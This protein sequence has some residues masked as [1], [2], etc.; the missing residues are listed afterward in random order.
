MT[1]PITIQKYFKDPQAVLD[2]LIDWTPWLNGDTIIDS[3]FSVN[4]TN[5][6]IDS[7]SFTTSSATVWLSGGII[8]ETYIVTNHITT[9]AGRE[10][11]HSFR[12][13]IK[14]K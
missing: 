8:G 6:I 11:D 2:Y 5:L 13:I 4:S 3:S 12:I 1:Y 14:D 9:F 10:D 7:S